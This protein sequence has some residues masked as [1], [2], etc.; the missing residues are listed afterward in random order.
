MKKIYILLVL[1]TTAA[2]GQPNS[3]ENKS[4]T[5][6]ET[7]NWQKFTGANY[8]IQYPTNW[9]LTEFLQKGIPF[10]VFSPLENEVDKFKENINLMIQ[11]LSGRNIDL[12]KYVAL[13]EE[14]V[15]TMVPNSSLLE[16]KRIKSGDTEFHKVIYTGVQNNFHLQFE[17]H[18]W[19][20]NQKAYILTLTCEQKK[21]ADE[22][23]LGEKILNSFVL[24]KNN[25]IQ[26]IHSL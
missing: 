18:Y 23:I 26:N 17:Q 21:F 9:Q 7:A 1:I 6:K 2:S 20:I 13:S 11:D 4:N 15:K 10:C 3:E 22:Q 5:N 24:N 19:V 25:T 8:A 16:S 12:N 14:Q